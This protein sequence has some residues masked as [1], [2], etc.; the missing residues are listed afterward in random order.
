MQKGKRPFPEPIL[1]VVPDV[2][3]RCL[4]TKAAE[5]PAPRELEEHFAQAVV[6][7]LAADSRHA[8]WLVTICKLP[9]P[10]PILARVPDVVKRGLAAGS[11]DAAW[12]AVIKNNQTKAT[13]GAPS[14]AAGAEGTWPSVT[15]SSDM[16]V[17]QCSDVT[18]CSLVTPC[19]DAE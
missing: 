13:V 12:L 14:M 19:S 4:A 7:R 17:T 16:L 8:A 18:Q 3:K 9:D 6:D 15:W 2:V 10:E 11:Q 5:R 1:A